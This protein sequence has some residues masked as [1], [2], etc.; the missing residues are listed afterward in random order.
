VGDVDQ[1][2]SVT[3]AE[4]AQLLGVGEQTIR[5]RIKRGELVAEQITRPQGHAWRVRLDDGVTRSP[6]QV[7]GHVRAPDQILTTSA[8][9][10]DQV[11]TRT[12]DQVI[13]QVSAGDPGPHLAAALALAGSLVDQL[14]AERAR[15]AA[16][17]H[18]RFG[19]AG[20]LGFLQAQLQAA[21]EQIKL[22]AAPTSPHGDTQESTRVDSPR[23]WWERWLWWRRQE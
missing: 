1:V 19:L 14:A 6:D 15:V 13:D 8:D 9:Q 11:L 17:E 23:P 16:L 5:R 21:Q 10:V 18:E 12:P 7:N 2:P 4:A 3:I 22:L 20:Q